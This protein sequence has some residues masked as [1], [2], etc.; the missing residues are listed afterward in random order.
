M[1]RIG[2]IGLGA[3]GR[4][5]ASNL[6]RKGFALTVFDVNPTPV[7][8]LVAAGAKAAKSVADVVESADIVFT[9]L[10]DSPDVEAVLLGE[11]GVIHAARD[12][13]L[14]VD[15]STIDPATTDKVAAALGEKG[16]GFADA[17]VG[18]LVMHAERG[19][20]LFMVGASDN[21]FGRMRPL[22]EAMGTTIHHCGP[23]GAG[24]RTKLVNNY[25][26][27]AVCQVNAEA[28]A[29]ARAFGLDLATTLEVVNGTTATNG[30]LKT[31][32]PNKVLV[33]DT[34][35]GFKIALAHKDMSLGVEAARKAGVPVFAGVAVRECLGLAKRSGDLGDKDFS[36]LLDHACSLAGLNPPRLER[37]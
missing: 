33:G 14:V 24:I 27:I 19:E 1:E 12:G 37:K 26:A 2:F 8:A 35:P 17:P 3:M 22:L 28:F 21:D 10:P 34:A 4:P 30:H 11:G 32:W 15:M 31:A 18:R 25:I 7:Q 6:V 9:M 13:L 36:A 29:L 5:M 23:P 16:V 20:S